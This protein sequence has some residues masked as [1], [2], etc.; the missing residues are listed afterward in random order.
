M[1]TRTLAT[2]SIRSCTGRHLRAARSLPRTRF[3]P[4]HRVKPGEAQSL[5]L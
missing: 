2:Q 5:A 1:T 4:V 3:Y